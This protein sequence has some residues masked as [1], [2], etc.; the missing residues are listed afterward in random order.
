MCRNRSDEYPRAENASMVSWYGLP[1][2]T[3]TKVSS[4]KDDG[5]WGSREENMSPH[6]SALS[7][8]DTRFT[9]RRWKGADRDGGPEGR[10]D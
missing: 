2:P 5:A 9:R 6:K 8:G 1:Q 3:W 4:V 10:G 7:M